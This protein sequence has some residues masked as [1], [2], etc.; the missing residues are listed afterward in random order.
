MFF[1]V[2]PFIMQNEPY[3]EF[4]GHPAEVKIGCKQFQYT[5]LDI[6]FFNNGW[7]ILPELRSDQVFKVWATHQKKSVSSCIFG[8]PCPDEPSFTQ[9]QYTRLI[10]YDDTANSDWS[11]ADL[12]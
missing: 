10:Y 1:K 12:L 3:Y 8:T 11:W 7:K 6:I 5:F 9:L 4:L 2:R